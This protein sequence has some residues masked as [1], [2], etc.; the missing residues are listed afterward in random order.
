MKIR[1]WL[2]ASAFAFSLTAAFAFK[3]PSVNQAFN[4][5]IPGACATLVKDCTGGSHLC[6]YNG[7]NLQLSNGTTCTA[8]AHM[9]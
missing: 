2:F 4:A 8:A 3:A 9:P 5:A 6:T 7:S 1:N